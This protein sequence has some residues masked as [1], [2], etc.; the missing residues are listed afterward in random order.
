M[1]HNDSAAKIKTY[2]IPTTIDC[3]FSGC[4]ELKSIIIPDSVTNIGEDAFYSCG[5][6][7]IV[8]FKGTAEKWNA[9]PIKNGNDNLLN[10]MCYYYSDTQ[11]ELNSEGTAYNGNYWHY[12]NGEI[13]IWTKDN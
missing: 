6:L 9:I 11:P 1:S 3:A 13:V 12:V 2:N 10:A 8:F 7:T 4:S 5:G